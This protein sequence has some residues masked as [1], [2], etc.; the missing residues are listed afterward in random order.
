MFSAARPQ[1]K[2]PVSA[3]SLLHYMTLKVQ[4]IHFMHWGT[5][6]IKSKLKSTDN[7]KGNHKEPN[8]NAELEVSR[9]LRVSGMEKKM[10]T[11]KQGGVVTNWQRYGR[12]KW[13]V[14]ET[15]SFTF[16]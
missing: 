9:I 10:R 15:H 5:K 12:D 6:Q 13:S 8:I 7:T 16:G 1:S 14:G 3:P 11:K 2:I 4:K